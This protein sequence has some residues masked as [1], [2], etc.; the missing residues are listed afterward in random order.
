MDVKDSVVIVTGAGTGIGQAL[1]K[2]FARHGALV[3][4]TARRENRLRETVRAIESQGGKARAMPADVTDKQQ[5][6]RLVSETVAEF[7]RV[8]ILFNNAGSFAALG[9]VWEVD[10]DL[11]WRDVTVN[12]RGTMLCC[13]AVLPHMIEQGRGIVINMT[14]GNQIPG[15]TGYSA[16]KVAVVRFTELLARELR[17]KESS[18]LAFIMGP[19]FVHTEMTDLQIRTAEGREWLPSS[20]NAVNT[21]GDRPPED[22]ARAT[23]QLIRVACPEL[24]GKTFGPDSDFDAERTAA[25]AE[26]Q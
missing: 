6:N 20:S 24:A 18:V 19:G 14:G 3:V 8:D 23:M 22:C 10:P 13:R 21:G 12:L 25:I 5:V 1:A 7:G 4:V 11:W 2:E 15:G 17:A 9:P 16:S 26:E